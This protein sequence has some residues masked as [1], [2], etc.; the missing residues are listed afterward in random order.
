MRFA[1]MFLTMW[2]ASAGL[3][4]HA[5]E[6]WPQFR[7]DQASGVATGKNLPDAWS[8]TKNVVWKTEIPGKS[9]SSPIVWGDKVFV[10]TCVAAGKAEPPKTGFY[11]PKATAIPPGEHRWM[12]FCLDARSG[13]VLWE[14]VAHQGRPEQT[15]H[16]KNNYA[17]ETPVT[18]GERVYAYFGNLGLFCY[19]LNGKE[20]WSKKWGS[21]PTRLG[22]GTG[23]SPILHR[24]RI[25]VVNDNEKTSFLSA[26]DKKTGKEIW[27]VE[28]DEKSSWATPFVWEHKQRTEII[29]S[30]TGKVRSYDLD[31]KLLWEL[32]G[33][34]EICIPTPVAAHDLLF[35]S[36]GYEFARPRPVYAIRPGAAG[37]ITLKKGETS[38]QFI[39]WHKEPAGAYHPSPLVYG[40]HL[41]VL[42][43]LGLIACYDARTGK[44]VYGKQRLGGSFA[45]SPWAYGGKIFCLS[46]D[47]DTY[48]IGAGHEFKLLG[49]NRLEEMCLATPAI[50]RERVF[51]RTFSKLYCIKNEDDPAK[52]QP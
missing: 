18:D 29:T 44:E 41:Y 21:F 10:T 28:R 8:T 35:I 34:S 38:N 24:D 20:L 6:N 40:D 49:K 50:S 2:V 4:L 36:S 22:W 12:V 17:P 32:S 47:G 26:L 25:Y 39:A 7:G 3:P 45:A 1:P 42:Y 11:A 19:D 48:V 16:V 14:K 43:S 30:A 5:G 13:K 15:V 23:A 27:R 52:D 37:D 46:E 9:W 33:M 51:I 31:G